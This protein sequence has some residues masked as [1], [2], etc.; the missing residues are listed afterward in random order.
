MKNTIKML[1][2]I[3][4]AAVIGFS[5]AGC[6]RGDDDDDDTKQQP[7]GGG[8]SAPYLT[9]SPSGTVTAGTTVYLNWDSI[10]GASRYNIYLRYLSEG[11]WA[12]RS[13]SSTSFG[14]NSDRDDIGETV[15]FKVAA[16]NSNGA[17]GAHSNVVSVTFTGGSTQPQPNTS[18]NGIWKMGNF[19]VNVSG[20]TGVFSALPSSSS[21]ALTQSA[22]EK[23]YIKIGDQYWRNLTSTG[24]LTWSGQQK[25]ITFNNS[26][27]TVA[28][29]TVW[30]DA[31]FTM[32]ADRQT[33]TVISSNGSGTTLTDTW[34]R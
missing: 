13:W 9:A 8:L 26:K 33:V 1:G 23:G 5:M 30:R 3:A 24:N 19:Q 12:S 10:S 16:V 27:P 6:G 14:F 2:I 34:T 28:T 22:I 21:A 31:T 20:T 25:N 7:S 32:S 4:L 18:L 17:E 11:Q 15:Q 29:G